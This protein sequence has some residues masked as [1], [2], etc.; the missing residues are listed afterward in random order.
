MRRKIVVKFENLPARAVQ[1][2][3]DSLVNIYGGCVSHNGNCDNICTCCDDLKCVYLVT[4]PIV[5][6]ACK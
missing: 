3:V 5:I 2:S 4:Y 1:L 6:Q